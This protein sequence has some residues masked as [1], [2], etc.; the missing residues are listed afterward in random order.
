MADLARLAFE[1]SVRSLDKQEEL[2]AELRSRTGLLLAASSLATSF[3]GRPAP[4]KEIPLLVLFALLSFVISLAA[5][6]YVLLPKRNLFFSLV[7]ARVFE[8][9]YEFRDNLEEVYRRL[10]YDL[11]RF[12]ETNDRI[13]NRLVWG[14]RVAAAG[15]AVE[16]VLL[17]ASLGGTLV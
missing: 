12:W 17:V 6:L 14:F 4:E 13:V 3:L 1:A 10:T 15:L 9:L 5:S 8:S 16:I 11:D 7:G 2:L